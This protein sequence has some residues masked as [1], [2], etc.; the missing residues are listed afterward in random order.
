MYLKDKRFSPEQLQ[1]MRARLNKDQKANQTLPKPSDPEELEPPKPVK[2]NAWKVTKIYNEKK[3]Q[4]YDSESKMNGVS[5][6]FYN[7]YRALLPDNQR[8]EMDAIVKKYI[9]D[10]Y[11]PAL[12]RSSAVKIIHIKYKGNKHGCTPEALLKLMKLTPED[13]K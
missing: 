1:E 2:L 5:Q 13:I 11:P 3:Q 6:A 10:S 12:A 7:K 4:I 9:A 8:A